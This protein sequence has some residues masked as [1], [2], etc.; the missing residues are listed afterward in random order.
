MGS[1]SK[2]DDDLDEYN[3]D[4]VTLSMKLDKGGIITILNDH[5]GMKLSTQDFSQESLPDLQFDNGT[6]ML[7]AVDIGEE[8]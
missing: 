4:E 2:D 7:P 6:F 5:D 1:T 3:D 8:Y